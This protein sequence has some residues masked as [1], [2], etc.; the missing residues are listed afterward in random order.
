MHLLAHFMKIKEDI[1]YFDKLDRSLTDPLRTALRQI[2]FMSDKFNRSEVALADGKLV[3]F[4]FMI[5]VYKN[6]SSG[7]EH[8]ID[9]AKPII[10]HVQ[11]KFPNHVFVRGEISILLPG[12]KLKPHIDRKW[13][14]ANCHRMH[15]PIITN[16]YCY[17]YFEKRTR[18]LNEDELVEINN[19]I[20]H[21]GANY[22]PETR[23]HCIFDIMEKVKF[24]EAVDQKIDFNRIENSNISLDL[25]S[26]EDY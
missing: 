19:R 7:V 10:D 17:H 14:H 12:I 5:H 1:R 25:V 21:S 6:N 13:F 23:V 3:E 11:G 22:G 16:E 8:L 9:L 2:N 20:V 15:V 18:H 26:N 24:Q 4:P